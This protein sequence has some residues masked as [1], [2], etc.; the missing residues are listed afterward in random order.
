MRV[1]GSVGTRG[2]DPTSTS[3]KVKSDVFGGAEG[4][5]SPLSSSP[6]AVFYRRKTAFGRLSRKM[7]GRR[8]WLTDPSG[9]C[10]ED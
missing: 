2:E 4:T 5:F 6:V 9:L 7:S 3:E 1:C 8:A 10:K